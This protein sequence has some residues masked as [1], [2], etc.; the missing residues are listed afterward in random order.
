MLKS[1]DNRKQKAKKI[2]ETLEGVLHFL[3]Q[4]G[5]DPAYKRCVENVV[6]RLS[7]AEEVMS[8]A[9][10]MVSLQVG[11]QDVIDAI[12]QYQDRYTEKGEDIL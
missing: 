8:V 4:P 11:P 3:N 10:S 12:V 5:I 9:G 7:D 6:V 2:R 1:W